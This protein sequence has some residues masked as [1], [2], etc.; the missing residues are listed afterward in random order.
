MSYGP[1]PVSK[2]ARTTS[3]DISLKPSAVPPPTQNLTKRLVMLVATATKATRATPPALED[4]AATPTART[5]HV[6]EMARVIAT[7]TPT[8]L[9]AAHGRDWLTSP[10]LLTMPRRPLLG[11]PGPPL[12]SH[13]H[14]ACL[15]PPGGASAGTDGS[16]TSGMLAPSGAGPG[17]Q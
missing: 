8:M 6:V 3:Q 5:A 11:H 15:P 1:L 16:D 14:R 2:S 9:T 17:A 12:L 10:P 7:N 4:L 13:Q